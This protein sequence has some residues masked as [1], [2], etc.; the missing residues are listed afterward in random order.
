MKGLIY[1]AIKFRKVTLF[2]AVFLIVIGIY[3]Y[4][5]TP[6]QEVPDIT[7]SIAIVTT[8]YP[9]ASPEDVEKLVTSRIEDDAAVISGFDYSESTS[10]NSLSIVVV[11]LDN[12]ADIDVAWSEL[13]QKMDDLQSK[14]PEGCE[15][16]E[17]MTNLDETAGIIIS[18]SGE[19]YTY[20]E[21][22]AYADEFKRELSKI[23]GISRFE[24]TGEQKRQV[25]V[26][27]DIP[28]LN[29]YELSLQDISKIIASQNIEIPSGNLDDGDMKINVRTSGA[30]AS[31]DEIRNTII[32]VSK[33]DGSIV[34]LK[35]IAKVY[36]DYEDSNF[37]IKQNGRNAIL[38]TGYIKDEKNIVLIGKEV[39][40]EIEELRK[41]LPED[42]L[43]DSVLFQPEDVSKSV[44]DFITNLIQGV[45]FVI[46][47]VF[48]GMG[49]KN[50]IIVSTSI[51][52]S[53]LMSF[54]VMRII[55]INI[56]MISI[57]ALII[58]L[59]MLV[60]NA[61]VVS[62]AIQVRIDRGQDKLRAC[63]SGVKEV[64]IPI[65]SSTLTTIGAFIPLITL[66]A[67]AGEYIKSLPQ[68]VITSLFSSYLVALFVTPTMAFMFFEKSKKKAKNYHIRRFFNN[69]L[70][71]GMK[72]K[73]TTFIIIFIFLGITVF[74]VSRIGLQFFPKADKDLIYIDIE[75]ERGSDLVKTESIA[76]KV[77]EILN[78]QDEVTS[79][80]AAMGNGLPKFY[81]TLSIYTESQ[82]FAQFM[83]RLDLKI[84]NRFKRNTEFVNYIQEIFDRKISGGTATA[85]ELEV[86][87]PIGAPM[88]IRV[89]GDDIGRLNEV[90][91]IIK[92]KLDSIKGTINVDDDFADKVYEFYVD[93]NVNKASSFGI[94]K[95]DVQREVNTALMGRKTSVF[96]S[97][98]K[99]YNIVLN[100]N[101]TSK[102]ALENLAIKSSIS[103][104]KVILKEI[105]QIKLKSQIPSIR[106][107]DREKA[108]TIFSDV[109]SG[110]NPIKI[111]EELQQKIEH[112]DL[113]DINI[114]FDGE[115][116]KIN[117]HFGN[118]RTSSIFA[119]LVV[120][121]ILLVQFNSFTQPLV[122]LI[123][124][125]LSSIGSII[126]LYVFRQPLSF[127]GLLGIVSLFGIVVNNAIILIDFI[128][129]ERRKG[130][131]IQ[132][133]CLEAVD[134]RF[135]PI[136]LSTTTTVI[137]L[138]PLVLSGSDLFTPM[139]I[140][141]MC[142]LMISTLLTLVIIPIV[143][144]IVERRL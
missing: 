83:V 36:M 76:D 5:I 24:I 96:R 60:D 124:I 115:Q 28:K 62:D 82:D 121:C 114:V 131:N 144:S 49:F 4:Y 64:A 109:K 112:V 117:E 97:M 37:E 86:G 10:K 43:F 40:K 42:I 80:T 41:E 101:I 61:I 44:N 138:T 104:K 20:E 120:F 30:Y 31:I 136:M 141:L 135:R 18:M 6:K 11:R 26:E 134:K 66:P 58:S 93:V 73:K 125:P 130:K 92:D 47:V 113:G 52:L 74:F 19:E 17:V 33:S 103:G 46:I 32:S 105:A 129:S 89:T 95:Y 137:G 85:K 116:A 7:T 142:G 127:M 39:E 133:A 126:G 48:I 16:I 68:I 118:I 13:R 23:Q 53:I 34:R 9:G 21:L 140:S 63:V 54:S 27:V 50:A 132:T 2:T 91:S 128:N 79:Y 139:S 94:S 67:M 110:F 57:A 45:L 100:S 69:L 15:K 123:T 75:T 8:V 65:L 87:E 88:V 1:G 29:Y 14:L 77:S 3:N 55:G 122:I 98:G 70:I 81:N 106:K 108:V 84:G 35:D 38:L 71:K 111:Q 59:G 12:D 102:E 143:Y 107:H 99:E 25:N 22:T 56:H 51:P 90:A 72:R 78:D 119:V